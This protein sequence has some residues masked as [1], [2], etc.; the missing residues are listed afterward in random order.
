[1]AQAVTLPQEFCQK[2]DACRM[3]LRRQNN[4]NTL[5]ESCN[6]NSE[7]CIIICPWSTNGNIMQ[8]SCTERSVI[9]GKYAVNRPFERKCIYFLDSRIR[10]G[11]RYWKCVLFFTV[12]YS[13][14]VYP[15]VPVVAIAPNSTFYG[16]T[17]LLE[18]TWKNI[19]IYI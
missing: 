11:I 16:E 1:M 17:F 2:W 15:S 12:P 8:P 18:I 3:R 19:Y 7:V 4:S 10:C 13:L 9:P 14:C 6:A 5:N